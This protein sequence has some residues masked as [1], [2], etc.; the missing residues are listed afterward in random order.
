MPRKRPALA[1]NA[2][3]IVRN[4]RAKTIEALEAKSVA[5]EKTI[6]DL[7]AHK[8]WASAIRQKHDQRFREDKERIAKLLLDVSEG[9]RVYVEL[10]DVKKKMAD[11]AVAVQENAVALHQKVVELYR[12]HTTI[13]LQLQEVQGRALDLMKEL[14]TLRT[15]LGIIIEV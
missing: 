15:Q 6:R 2:E 1:P 10:T 3:P 12:K 9:E 11:A 13:D 14:K 8:K 4:T 5:D 7:E